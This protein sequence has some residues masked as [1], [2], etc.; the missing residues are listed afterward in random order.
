MQRDSSHDQCVSKRRLFRDGLAGAREARAARPAPAPNPNSFSRTCGRRGPGRGRGK[1]FGP[2][3]SRVTAAEKMSEVGKG[4]GGAPAG[5]AQKKTTGRRR[6]P[7]AA[8]RG[9]SGSRIASPPALRRDLA[10][11]TTRVLR[12]NALLFPRDTRRLAKTFRNYPRAIPAET[13]GACSPSPP[14][15]SFQGIWGQGSPAPGV[16]RHPPGV[17]RPRCARWAGRKGWS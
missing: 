17:W 5:S 11:D 12:P 7:S 4:G 16:R 8:R 1:D 3:T 14:P 2:A 13:F 6:P 9:L 10:M 15:S